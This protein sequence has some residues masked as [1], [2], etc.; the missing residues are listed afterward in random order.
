MTQPYGSGVLPSTLADSGSRPA[1][2]L[3]KYL[4]LQDDYFR[5]GKEWDPE[6]VKLIVIDNYVLKGW[7]E[8]HPQLVALRKYPDEYRPAS[9]K[10][11]AE[12]KRDDSSAAREA[13]K[14]R[15]AAKAQLEAG[16]TEALI[17]GSVARELEESRKDREAMAAQ[18]KAANEALERS[19]ALLEK[20]AATNAGALGK[21]PTEA[22]PPPTGELVLTAASTKAEILRWA[23]EHDIVVPDDKRSLGRAELAD[24]VLGAAKKAAGDPDDAPF[25]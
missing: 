18:L 7:P 23:T 3:E 20:L 1:M 17:A 14:L 9:P 19:N 8:E 5:L 15:E 12:M 11:L 16:K 4:T 24:F 10:R 2:P 13:A 22:P 25:E 6:A 21:E